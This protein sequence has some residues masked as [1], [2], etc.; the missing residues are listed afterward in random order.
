MLPQDTGLGHQGGNFCLFPDPS[1]WPPS[2]PSQEL[3]SLPVGDGESPLGSLVLGWGEWSGL[4]WA[5]GPSG[6]GAQ[7]LCRGGG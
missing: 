6:V 3:L 2:L 4:L 5:A 1:P 7:L